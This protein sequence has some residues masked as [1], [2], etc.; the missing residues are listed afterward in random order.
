MTAQSDTSVRKQY[1]YVHFRT[2]FKE[3]KHPNRLICTWHHFPPTEAKQSTMEAQNLGKILIIDDN[4]DLLFA[5]K[6]LLKKHAK[7]V[8]IEKDP[9]R[10]PFLINNHSY[11]VILL[12]MNFRE[13]TTSGKEGFY[14]LKQIKEIDPKAVVILITA[15]GDVEM[16][17]QALKEGATDFILKPWQNE[18]LIA[19]LSSAIKL[20][21]SYDEVDKLQKKTKAAT[22]RP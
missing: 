14:W 17:V 21:E 12:D 19:T 1:N 8:M 4:E 11:D 3:K 7:E 10:I 20:K 18:K 9:R 13:D 16:A 2:F 15:F 5:A 22:N 6:M